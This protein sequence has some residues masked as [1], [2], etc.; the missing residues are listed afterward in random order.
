MY[1]VSP[2]HLVW[3]GSLVFSGLMRQVMRPYVMSFA[4]AIGTLSFGM[5]KSVSVPITRPGIPCAS[6][7]SLFPEE[8]DHVAHVLGFVIR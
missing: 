8:W 5:K 6:H 2:C 4:L 1:P 3:F 7:P